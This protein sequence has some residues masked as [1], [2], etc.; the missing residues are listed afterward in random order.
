[1]SAIVKFED[2]RQKSEMEIFQELVDVAI[3]SGNYANKSKDHLLNLMFTAKELGIP[4]MKAIN[5]GFYIVQGKVCMATWLM[6]DRI[7]EAG[8]SIRIPEWTSE[9]CIVMGIRKD[10]GDSIKFEFTMEDAKRAKLTEKQPWK[11]YPKHMLY[12][13]AM[14]TIGR[15]LFPDVVGNVYSEDEMDGFI[16]E[17]KNKNKKRK[18]TQQQLEE[19][20]SEEV[21]I[22][23]E[24]EQPIPTLEKDQ[25]D[26]IRDL[27]QQYSALKPELLE[28]ILKWVGVTSLEDVPM[29]KYHQ[30]VTG[31]TS[32]YGS[33]VT[34]LDQGMLP[35][36]NTNS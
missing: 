20:I 16:E 34:R 26:H 10:N 32:K 11:E 13:R 12:A 29:D 4:P 28:N 3:K 36:C 25:V 7:R 18:N 22:Q 21:T 23:A 8:H 27:I 9:K 35:A 19:V 6:V 2:Q 17:D 30:I 31:I 24:I 15:V 33:K 5:G 1:M 14:S